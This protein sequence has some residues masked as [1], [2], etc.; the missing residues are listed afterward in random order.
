M[1]AV[2]VRCVLSCLLLIVLPSCSRERRSDTKSSPEDF[3]REWIA[4]W[5]SRDVDRIL[6]FYA[7]DASYEDVPTLQ[8]GW[9]EPARGRA[10]IRESVEETFQGMPD[11]GFE[12]VS[13]SGAGDR[14]VVEW[15]M[16]GTRYRGHTGSFSVRGV[17]VVRREG[18]E[19]ASVSDYYDS[20]VLLSRLG[21]VPA[22]DAEDA[23][24]GGASGDR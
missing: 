5:D 13:A 21:I 2:S 8:N 6:S 22:L 20:Y 24:P 3:A 18:G 11:L 14:M 1:P 4:A 7:E 10:R 12:L 15:I 23:A 9:G 19:I 17:S 16:T